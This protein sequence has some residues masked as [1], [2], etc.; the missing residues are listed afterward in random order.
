MD[1]VL[2][3]DHPRLPLPIEVTKY[4]DVI[5]VSVLTPQRSF[6]R[7]VAGAL[8]IMITVADPDIMKRGGLK[9]LELKNQLPTKNDDWD[10]SRDLLAGAAEAVYEWSGS[11]ADP[12]LGIAG[13][14]QC[15]PRGQRLGGSGGMPPPQESFEF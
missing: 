2:K 14:E 7:F 4:V 10:P 8:S 13:P 9:C 15:A 12:G 1:M 5:Y 3:R 11:G 6:S